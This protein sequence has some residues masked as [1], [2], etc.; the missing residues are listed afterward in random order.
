MRQE[1]ER[2]RLAD[3]PA[4]ELGMTGPAFLDMLRQARPRMLP[5]PIGSQRGI[6]TRRWASDTWYLDRRQS[7]GDVSPIESVQLATWACRHIQPAPVFQL[8]T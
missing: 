5:T 7:P 2:Y 4:T 3:M 1:P 6:A 8:F